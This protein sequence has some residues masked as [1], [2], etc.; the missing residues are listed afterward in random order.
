MG[1]IVDIEFIVQFLVLS[2]ANKYNE[3]CRYTDNVRILDACSQVNL[4]KVEVA[5]ELQAIYLL[6]RKHLH[7]LSLQML[8]ESVGA[9][10]FANER[11][12]VQN[13]WASLLH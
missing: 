4:I 10:E 5:E 9:D 3:I 6:Y 8:S 12:A 13:Y 11:L 2:Y 1:G 7:Q